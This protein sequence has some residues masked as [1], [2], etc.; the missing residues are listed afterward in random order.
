MNYLV[1]G[2]QL[3]TVRKKADD[4]QSIDYDLSAKPEETGTKSKTANTLW[5]NLF[6]HTNFLW[7]KLKGLFPTTQATTHN[8]LPK[9][10]NESKKLVKSNIQDDGSRVQID[11]PLDLNKK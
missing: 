1:K 7:S 5:Q 8:Y 2:I 11:S 9:I 4:S 10:D 6:N 3:K